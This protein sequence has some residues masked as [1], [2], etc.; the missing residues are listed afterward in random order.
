MS[1]SGSPTAP[2]RSTRAAAC[3]PRTGVGTGEREACVGNP[4][5]FKQLERPLQG[6]FAT[7]LLVGQDRLDDLVAD[8]QRW[9]ERSQGS[10]KTI[11]MR[12]PRSSRR[13]GSETAVRSRP[14]N[15][16]RHRQRQPPAKQPQ[17]GQRHRALPGA[18]LAHQPEHRA[19][20]DR[21]RDAVHR[22]DH[23]AAAL[24]LRAQVLDF[25]QRSASGFGERHRP[26]SRT[27]F[28]SSQSRSPPPNRLNPIT[29]ISIAMPGKIDTQGAIVT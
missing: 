2:A 23:S 11:A 7:Q 3:R 16:S 1:R 10:W 24:E 14:E 19:R 5:L 27:S 21:E 28:G 20:L 4:D 18:G 25:E 22:A 13:R 12:S 8:P 29:V 17:D 15:E 26:V 6:I 9:G